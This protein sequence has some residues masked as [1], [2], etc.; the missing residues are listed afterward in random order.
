MLD[1]TIK[2]YFY[3]FLCFNVIS[4]DDNLN[5]SVITDFELCFRNYSFNIMSHNSLMLNPFLW[6]LSFEVWFLSDKFDIQF[7]SKTTSSSLYLF[8]S[9]Y[10]FLEFLAAIAFFFIKLHHYNCPSHVYGY[11]FSSCLL[12]ARIVEI[13]KM[14]KIQF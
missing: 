6:Y 2:G 3:F 9:K 1:K 5:Y 14:P 11:L 12:P 13:F 8:L 4:F 7:V 10:H